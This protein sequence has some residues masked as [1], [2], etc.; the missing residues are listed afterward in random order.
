MHTMRLVPGYSKRHMQYC[1]GHARCLPWA[2]DVA[3]HEHNE[4]ISIRD[5]A[6]GVVGENRGVL[7]TSRC[8]IPKI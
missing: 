5:S 6:R 1:I 7:M 3:A 2:L 8:A 4:G